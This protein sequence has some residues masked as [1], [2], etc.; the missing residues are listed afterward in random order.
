LFLA[1]VRKACSSPPPRKSTIKLRCRQNTEG[2]VRGDPAALEAPVDKA[3]LAD[4]LRVAHPLRAVLR[5][6]REALAADRPLVAAP[7]D[8]AGTCRRNR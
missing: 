2:E 6:T 3:D 8:R 4:L 7:V 5:L 1:T